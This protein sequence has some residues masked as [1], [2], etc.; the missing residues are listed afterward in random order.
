MRKAH[1]KPVQ[2]K[3]KTKSGIMVFPNP[4]KESIKISCIEKSA[5]IQSYDM[6]GNLLLTKNVAQ[7]NAEINIAVLAKGIYRFNTKS[8]YYTY[9][10]VKFSIIK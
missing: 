6:L 7:N 5:V 9:K 4:S 3:A 8:K 2:E 1:P 10:N